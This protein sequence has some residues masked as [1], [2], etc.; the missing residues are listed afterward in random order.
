MNREKTEAPR[1]GLKILGLFLPRP[2]AESIAGDYEELFEDLIQH[3]GRIYCLIWYWIQI[4][5]SIFSYFTLSF[6]WS[7]VM[8][9]N[10]I[11]IALR[12]IKNYKGYS[13]I[14]IL[15]LA[16]GI[17]C[18]TLILLWV[19]NETN[20]DSF[21]ENKDNLY[22]VTQEGISVTCAA[23]APALKEEIPEIALSSRYRTIGTRLVKYGGSSFSG[24]KI[25][26]VDPDFF[27]MFSF[28]LVSGDPETVLNEPFSMVLTEETAE[29][30]FGDENPIGKV[31][32]V[33]SRF[34]L[35]VKGVI[36]N[37]PRNSHMQF[38]ILTRFD[39]L[40][41]LW[42][43]DITSW[44]SNSHLSYIQLIDY[45]RPEAATDKINDVYF[46]HNPNASHKLR[47]FPVTEIY[48]SKMPQWI[49]VEPGSYTYVYVFSIIA[50]FILLIACIN[51]MNLST[52]RSIK[53]AKE[54][55]VR[56]VV[57]ARKAD[58]IKQFYGESI[59][60]TL[61][62]FILAFIIIIAAL[63]VFNNLSGKQLGISSLGNL[64]VIAGLFLIA[65]FT[66][67]LSGSYPAFYLS[68]FKPANVLKTSTL[69][70]TAGKS[71]IRK[72]LV[73][74]QFVLTIFLI[75]GTTVIYRQ[76]DY[77]R[78]QELGYDRENIITMP[79]TYS[80]LRQI[81]A[82]G[83]EIAK[84]PDILG[85][86]ISGT[87][88]GIME[89]TT[90]KMTW[91]GKDPDEFI[92]FESIIA[93]LAF[94]E[95]FNL[96][97]V[98]GRYFSRDHMS[99]LRNG[100]VVN[101]TAV[102]TMG[103]VD[104]SP[105]GKEI[106]N[107]PGYSSFHSDKVRIIGVVKDFHSRSFHHEIAP[108]ILIYSPYA[109][110]NLSIRIRDGKTAETI[111]F[112]GDIWKRFVPDYPFEYRFFDERINDLYKAEQRMG[113]LLNYFTIIAI[114][115]SC[116]GLLGLAAFTAQQRTKE[117]GIRK[118]FG[119]SVSGILLLISKEFIILVL[120][121][122]VI[123]WPLSYYVSHK[124][125]ERFA[126]R[127]EPAVWIFIAAGLLT[128]VVA[129]LTVSFQAFRAAQAKPVDSLRYE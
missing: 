84:N 114:F 32:L 66:G 105:L 88:P 107:I 101:E 12:N 57:G 109:N 123:A 80:L 26:L 17:A 61:F 112:L 93:D 42:G 54:S 34:S 60:S 110:D 23:L 116:L 118:T 111:T 117:I 78:S 18:C 37:I 127:A 52:A 43:E 48:L 96:K 6:H 103:I 59:I 108:L 30:Y 47:L 91:D 72:I 92:R 65:I 62:A 126:F 98:E 7:K 39:F 87:L 44:T 33:D 129:F 46:R 77:I 24:D 97:I 71:L 19:R 53:R 45:S 41:D 5:K 100:V 85:V 29:K 124:W 121:A 28:P 69:G 50:L 106:S 35:T 56:K 8:Y 22:R 79:A 3:K 81:S 99:E 58:L 125:L 113:K 9:R 75:I 104:E 86:T 67:V 63:P 120:T 38:D 20:F 102:R 1:S 25:S 64:Y 82:A 128:L 14:N 40:N 119:A 83:Q 10:Y 90:S 73:I 11:K 49:D 13:A 36:K 76:L 68:S 122:I 115:I 2:E 31:L 94:L 55:G 70:G 89:T 74:V 95:T 21:H 15:G 51:F 27:R 16:I 4:A